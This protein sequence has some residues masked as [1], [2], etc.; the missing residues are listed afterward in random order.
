[1]ITSINQKL[2][3]LREHRPPP[4]ASIIELLNDFCNATGKIRIVIRNGL[5]DPVGNFFD[6][7]VNPD[8]R[9]RTPGSGR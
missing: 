8:F 4:N 9:L 3:V 1:M 7:A 6:N 5:P 2:E